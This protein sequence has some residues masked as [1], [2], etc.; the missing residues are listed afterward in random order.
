MHLA[1][2]S[3]RICT[4]LALIFKTWPNNLSPIYRFFNKD[5]GDWNRDE[6]GN[7]LNG[8]DSLKCCSNSG[9]ELTDEIALIIIV[10]HRD[11]FGHGEI[12]IGRKQNL[13]RDNRDKNFGKLYPCRIFKAQ[14]KL[15]ELGLDEL[16]KVPK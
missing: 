14:L 16:A 1:S 10:A 5:R 6:V 9:V 3:F 11:E 4:A 7:N 13:Y 15:V 12:G 2:S 8:L